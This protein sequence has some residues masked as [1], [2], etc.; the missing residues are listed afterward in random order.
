MDNREIEVRFLEINKDALIAKLRE[1]GATDHGEDF[2]KEVIFYDPDFKW[3]H[4]RRMVRVR[5]TNNSTVVTYKHHQHQSAAGTEE[6]EF[7]ADSAERVNALLEKIGLIAFRHQ[8]KYR[9]TFQLGGVT[10]DIDTWPK[11]PTYVEL[12]G[13][14][15]EMLQKVAHRL[16]LD[17][18]KANMTDARWVIENIYNIPV[19]KLRYFTFDKIE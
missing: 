14:S 1:L 9:Y 18:A 12:E 4:E 3:R 15:E 11:I 5:S 17:W 10:I 7:T 16:G 8:E 2:L 13:T 19:S 6:V